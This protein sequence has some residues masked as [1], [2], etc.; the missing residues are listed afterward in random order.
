MPLSTLSGLKYSTLANWNVGK[1]S[2]DCSRGRPNP[3]AAWYVRC[4]IVR[5]SSTYKFRRLRNLVGN[6]MCPAS[7]WSFNQ[8]VR[9]FSRM[10]NFTSL[11]NMLMTSRKGLYDDMLAFHAFVPKTTRIFWESAFMVI[12]DYL[13]SNLIISRRA[14]STIT[15]ELTRKRVG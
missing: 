15:S 1:S 14:A 13:P 7:V 8:Y 3:K 5:A 2:D 4:A 12:H 10:D 11:D 9:H 6:T